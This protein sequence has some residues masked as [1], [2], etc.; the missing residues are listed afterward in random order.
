MAKQILNS[1]QQVRC[2]LLLKNNK[3]EKIICK[4]I[5]KLV[6]GKEKIIHFVLLRQSLNNLL[7]S[8]L[9]TDN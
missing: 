6:I 1:W 9:K 7:I 5:Y 8:Y 2:Q 3:G 4:N